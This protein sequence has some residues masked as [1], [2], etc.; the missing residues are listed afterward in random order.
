MGTPAAIAENIYWVGVVDWNIRLFH[1]PTLSTPYGTT[2]NSYLIMDEK[3]ALVDTVYAPFTDDLVDK[4]KQLI[5][6]ARIDYLVINHIEPDHSGAF[7]VIRRLCPNA[8][9]FCSQRA[10]EGLKSY[11]GGEYDYT[12]VKSGDTLKL[13]KNTLAFI[14]A[15]MLHWPDSMFT[16][17]PEQELLLPNDAFGQHLATTYRFDDEGELEFILGEAAKY[18]ANILMPFS[19]QVLK[20]LE[21][22]QKLGIKIKTIAP[23]HGLIWRRNPEAILSAYAR[24]AESKGRPKAVIAYDTMWNS[25]EKMAYALMDGLMAGGA[26][27]KLFKASVSDRS[28]VMKEVLDARAV[29]VG[30]P[31]MNNDILPVVSPLLDELVGLRPRNKIGMAFGSYGWAGGAQKIIEER[32]KAAKIELIEPGP[33]LKWAPADADL[34]RCRELGKEIARRIAD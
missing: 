32:L 10:L 29:L 22:V 18:Y 15:P 24:W 9:V 2:Y 28:D 23:S 13:G 26:E 16:Y 4:L 8:K 5:D 12:V 17:I 11:Y 21:E 30:S 27:V 19:A 34:D 33:S 6:P 14:E 1:G 3:N 31:T 20:K 25:T 7:P